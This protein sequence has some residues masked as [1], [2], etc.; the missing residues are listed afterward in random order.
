MWEYKTISEELAQIA[1]GNLT[2]SL[3]TLGTEGW[4]LVTTHPM[5]NHLWAILKRPMQ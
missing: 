2:D 3:N 4:E 1:N 5:G